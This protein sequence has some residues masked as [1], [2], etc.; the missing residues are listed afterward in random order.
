MKIGVNTW[1]WV[2]PL[3]T[4]ELEWLVPHIKSLGFDWIELAIEDIALVDLQRARQLIEAHGLG[5]SV[6]AAMGPDRDLIHPDPDIRANGMAYIRE[7]VDAAQT[8]GAHIVGGPLYSAVGRVWKQTPEEREQDMLLLIDQLRALAD[9]AAPRDV[10]LGVEA[11]NR[12]ETSFVNLIDQSI[13]IVDRVDHPACKVMVDTFHANIEE[14]KLGDALRRA[15]DRL[16]HVHTCENDR[17]APGTGHLPWEDV[18]AALK[19][20]NYQGA[21][22]IESFTNKVETIAKAAAIW[23]PLAPSQDDLARNGLQFL[24][25]LLN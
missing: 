5:V 20:I 9:Y 13:E 7:C 6:C 17:G 10:R 24:R 1:V 12:F 23:R 19:D 14:S 11:L 4:E 8:L 25:T 22:V 21:C 2:A 18:A 15:G 16:I 3:T